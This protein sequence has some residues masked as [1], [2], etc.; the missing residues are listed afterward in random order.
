MFS[1]IIPT[2]RIR[3]F[4]ANPVV[5]PPIM[6]A[7]RKLFDLRIAQ[8]HFPRIKSVARHQFITDQAQFVGNVGQL[9][10]TATVLAGTV[11]S[12]FFSP[13]IL[14]QAFFD[15]DQSKTPHYYSTNDPQFQ[16]AFR[17]LPGRDYQP[18]ATILVFHPGETSKTVTIPLIAANSVGGRREFTVALEPENAALTVGRNVAENV[19]NTGVVAEIVGLTNF[20][21]TVN[22]DGTRDFSCTLKIL[23]TSST[24][25]GPI[26]VSLVG[27]AG[28]TNGDS[29]PT[30][31]P[32]PDVDLGTFAVAVGSLAPNGSVP[33]AVN[34]TIPGPQGDA[35]GYNTWYWVYAIV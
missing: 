17:A 9:N 30:S 31:A 5:H 16:Q 35:Y 7:H 14:H 28:F 20:Q 10:Q 23:N 8:I 21:S 6:F 13:Q 24:V 26:W 11:D 4:V 33:I 22:S 25:A 12:S 2:R 15:G 29:G 3:P 1:G 18:T 34:A 32:P 19:V 27:H